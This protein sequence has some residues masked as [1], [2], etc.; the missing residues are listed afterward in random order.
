MRECEDANVSEI[1]R[2]LQ[3]DWRTAKKYADRE[4]VHQVQPKQRRARQVMQEEHEQRLRAWIEE[5]LLILDE[6]GYVPASKKALE[7]L[8]SLGSNSY[9]NQSILIASHL[10]LRRWN[11]VFG[12][13]RLTMLSSTGS[14]ITR[15][16]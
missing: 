14:F 15:T 2:R 4:C 3:V 13:D 6:I 1:A 11:E 7:L 5:D 9:E 8:F 16:F 10:E 12:D